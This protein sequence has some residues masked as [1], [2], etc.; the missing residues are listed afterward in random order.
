MN[1]SKGSRGHYF[2]IA[3]GKDSFINLD[4]SSSHNSL[5]STTHLHGE[6]A[7]SRNSSKARISTGQISSPGEMP[8][9]FVF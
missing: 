4:P 5:S 6:E 7:V 2:E 8:P 1:A 3:G 9:L